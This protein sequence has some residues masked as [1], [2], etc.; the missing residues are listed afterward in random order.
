MPKLRS[1][2]TTQGPN[3]AGAS[4]KPWQPVSRQRKVCDASKLSD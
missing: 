4:A 2:T 1:A 3:M